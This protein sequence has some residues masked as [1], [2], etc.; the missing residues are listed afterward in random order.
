MKKSWFLLM[1]FLLAGSGSPVFGQTIRGNPYNPYN[2]YLATEQR[3]LQERYPHESNYFSNPYG[4]VTPQIDPRYYLY[5]RDYL[6]RPYISEFRGGV[7]QDDYFNNPYGSI[8]RRWY[9][10][11]PGV[12]IGGTGRGYE[13]S[14]MLTSP[15]ED[16][17]QRQKQSGQ[18]QDAFRPRSSLDSE[19]TTIPYSADP[20]RWYDTPMTT[21]GTSQKS[22]EPSK[23][24]SPP[25]SAK[26]VRPPSA[27]VLTRPFE[28]NMPQNPRT[29]SDTQELTPPTPR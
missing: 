3:N 15:Y 22:P 2:P 25:Y 12:T 17:Y 28:T 10:V 7:Y 13:V 21:Q 20:R 5:E 11:Q 24:L 26:D 16:A 23:T 19:Y 18:P 27:E 8:P 29:F 6:T 1:A 4:T 9:D 14:G